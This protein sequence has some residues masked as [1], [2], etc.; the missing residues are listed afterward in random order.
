MNKLFS[1][2]ELRR[3]R[4]GYYDLFSHFYDRII[5]LHSKDKNAYLRRFLLEKSGVKTGD[6]VLDICTGTGAVALAAAGMLGPKSIVIGADFSL[7]MLKRSSAK[8]SHSRPQDRAT[9]FF[10]QADVAALPFNSSTFHVVTCSH[11]MYELKPRIRDAALAEAGRVLV[12][13]GRFIMMEHCE[14][15]TP[16]I[17]FLYNMRLAGMG[18]KHNREFAQDEIPF[19]AQYFEDV[20]RDV[21]PTGKS[22]VIYGHK[23]KNGQAAIGP[24][25]MD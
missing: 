10:V 5:A 11:A 21:A 9:L 22:K 13:G 8:Y 20:T 18:L 1:V 25:H 7:G 15:R 3:W 14:P 23:G 19:L 4:R 24:L 12:T 2:P 17:R 6:M 16:F